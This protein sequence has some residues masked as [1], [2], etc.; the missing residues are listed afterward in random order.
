MAL[1]AAVE[2]GGPT[3]W[4]FGFFPSRATIGHPSG[5]RA[6]F[7]LALASA[8][9]VRRRPLALLPPQPSPS[10]GPEAA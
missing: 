4:F 1:S 6:G 2:S 9:S 3:L 7:P 5:H 8:H 10:L